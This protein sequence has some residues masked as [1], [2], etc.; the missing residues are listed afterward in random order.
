MDVITYALSKHYTDDSILGTTGP[1][2]GKPCTISSIE[3][4]EGGHKVTFLWYDNSGSS[5]TSTM[6]VMDGAEVT[7]ISI[8]ENNHLIFTFSDGREIDGGEIP[9]AD[10]A[11]EVAYDN[12]SYPDLTNVKLALDEALQ[13]GAKLSNPLT[14]SNPVGSATNGKVYARNTDLET[15]IRDMLIKEVAPSLTL[16]ISPSTTLYDKVTQTVSE[17]IMTASVSKNTYNL[18]RIE[19]YLG[20]TLKYTQNIST[21][22]SYQYT[23]TWDE[24]TNDDFTL[25]AIVYDDR[26]GTPMST[27]KSTTVKF[28]GKSYYGTVASTVGE[29]TDAIVKA[30]ENN[31]L[32][33]TKNL[34]YSGITMAYGKIVY[35]YPATYG[36]LT[37]IM[38]EKNNLSYI[39]SFVRS[40]LTVDGLSYICYTQINPSGA[41]DLELVFH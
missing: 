15:I 3:N 25:K 35:A 10:E 38:D 34:T 6:N 7:D 40:T 26:S 22:G 36:N 23:V 4:I 30:L 31:S 33:D 41:D 12:A 21:N 32:K 13:S 37:Y 20:N 14:V 1:L 16:T 19:F 5:H 11:E 28:I 29:P 18:S 2:K 8:D 17:I 39:N 27:T 24:P 9:S